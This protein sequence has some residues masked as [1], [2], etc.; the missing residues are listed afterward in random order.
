MP[1]KVCSHVGIGKCHDIEVEDDVTCYMEFGSGMTGTFITST[2][3]TPGSNRFELAGTKG[4]LL[5][6]ND[7][8][9]F[10]RNAVASDAWCKTLTIGFRQPKTTVEEISIPAAEDPH[11]SL[12][13]NFVNAVLDGEALIAPG[14]EGLSSVELANAML[15]SGL[16]NEPIALPMDGAA[17]ELKL[18]ELIA[19]STHQKKV[20]EVSDVDFVA[21]FRR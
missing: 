16:I 18:N 9:E 14:E 10:S 6:E 8:L 15:Y 17:W 11:A 21:S 1:S 4:R 7:K 13:S 5:L 20:I 3:E 19:N 2:G 12:M